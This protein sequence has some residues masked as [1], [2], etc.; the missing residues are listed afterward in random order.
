MFGSFFAYNWSCFFCGLQ[1]CLCQSP[2]MGSKW[3]KLVGHLH[4]GPPGPKPRKILKRVSWG[5][6]PRDTPKVWKKCRKSLFQ[7]CS[8]LFQTVETFPDSQ[9]SG[10]GP[11][12]FF[13]TFWG[14]GPEGPRGSCKWSMGSQHLKWVENGLFVNFPTLIP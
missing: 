11:G 9:G 5:L 10:G 6:Q 2:E 7:T 8:R 3:T 1:M 4:S 14:F 13:Q 12:D